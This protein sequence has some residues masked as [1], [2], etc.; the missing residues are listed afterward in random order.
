VLRDELFSAE[1][2]EAHAATLADSHVVGSRLDRRRTLGRRLRDNER[3]LLDAYRATAATVAAGNSITPAAEWVLDNFHLVEEQIREIVLD[4]SPG[5]YRQLPKLADSPFDGYP[6]VFAIARAFIAHTDSR[7]DPTSFA[8]YLRAYQRVRPLTIAELWAVA[9]SLRM[10][11]VENLRRVVARTLRARAARLAADGVADQLLGLNG[12]ARDPGALASRTAPRDSEQGFEAQLI[13]RL[14]DQD[15]RETPA[16]QWLEEDLRERGTTADAVVSAEHQRQGASN[17]TVRNIIT[18]MRLILEVDWTE[19]FESVSL[20]D[21][22]LGRYAEYRRMDFATRNQYRDAIEQLARHSSRSELEIAGLAMAAVVDGADADG[23]PVKNLP[24]ADQDPGHR[25][26]GAG[27]A[28]FQITLGYRP[29][30]QR[31]IGGHL[32]G[33]GPAWY[34]GGIVTLASVVT[35][36]GVFALTSSGVGWGMA[37][38]LAMLGLAPTFELVVAVVNRLAM[39]RLGV[40]RL[41]GYA[42]RDGIPPRMRTMVVMPVLLTDA[43]SIAAYVDRLEVHYLASPEGAI[44][45]ALLCDGCDAPGEVMP[46]DAALLEVASLGVARL[47]AQY[48]SGASGPRFLMLCR[49]RVWCETQQAWMGWE[50]KRGKLHELNRLLRGASDTTFQMADASLP[51]VPADVRFVLTLDAD[52]RLPR[53]SVRLLVGKLAHPLNRPQLDPACGRI[54]AGY[55]VLQPRVTPSLPIDGGGSPFQAI[56]SSASGI[57]PYAAA[58]SDVYQDLVGEGSYTGKGIY[59]VDAFE[60][61]LLGRIPPETLLS[62][63]LFEGTFARAGLASD[64]AGGRGVSESLRRRHP[65][66]APLDPG[67]LATPALDR[68]AGR[69]KLRWARRPVADGPLEDDRQP[70]SQPVGARR[71]AFAAGV[72]DAAAP[73][74]ARVVRLPRGDELPAAAAADA[75]HDRHATGG[76]RLAKPRA[77]D[78][79]GA[80]A[81]DGAS[82]AGDRNVAAPGVVIAGRHRKDAHSAG[83]DA[84]SPARMDDRGAPRRRRSARPGQHGPLH[85]TR[86]ARFGGRGTARR[87]AVARHSV[88]RD[89]AACL[90]GVVTGLRAVDQ[91]RAG[92]PARAADRQRGPPRAAADRALHV[93]VLRELRDP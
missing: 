70:A 59:D 55:A 86:P 54:V 69:S 36:G 37:V 88:V 31:R 25:L 45:F 62:H 30:L 6:R 50:R 44:S 16:L 24:E 91:P 92:R 3:V 80:E 56:Y 67:R 58:S 1:R 33:H 32:R 26:I 71:L 57:D 79:A 19:F 39:R 83:G 89:A 34:V 22:E 76:C 52:T 28:A 66:A 73:D 29:P 85:G 27:R 13:Q 11:L 17:V 20:V 46:G 48:P 18:S 7:L 47:N 12:H 65:A 61:A 43:R 23:L 10:V 74:R 14:R 68:R 15:P 53:D 49:R 63:D 21:A 93:A 84:S 38:L 51:G 35:L 77:R 90:V 64:A 75:R 40:T 9:I 2:L 81:G 8:G 72:L 5:F 60:A 87:P 78:P 4:L 82:R 41:A 42:L